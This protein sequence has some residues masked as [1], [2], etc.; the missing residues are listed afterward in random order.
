MELS[1]DTD[2]LALVAGDARMMA[3]PAPRQAL[4]VP[5]A[6]ILFPASMAL[7]MTGVADVRVLRRLLRVGHHDT[8]HPVE[9]L[10]AKEHIRAFVQGRQERPGE[11]GM[12][13]AA[14][15]ALLNLPAKPG[16]RCRTLQHE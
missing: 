14:G 12:A 5:S 8:L 10:L 4:P 3:V 2:I 13:T 6:I 9:Q 1:S 16:R 7:L 15:G 11:H